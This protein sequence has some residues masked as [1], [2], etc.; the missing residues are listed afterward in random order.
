MPEPGRAPRGLG[1]SPVVWTLGVALGIGCAP[2][3]AAQ[4]GAGSEGRFVLG[5]RSVD[6]GGELDK[7][8][9]D[10][11]LG[12]GPRLM[13]LDLSFVPEGELRTLVD[14]VRVDVDDLGGEPFESLRIE[15]QRHGR[16]DFE[17]NRHESDYF[18]QDQLFPAD[19]VNVRSARAGDFHTFDFRRVRD[20]ASLGVDLAERATLTLGFD[21][22]RKTGR[23]TRA[24][25]LQR[26]EFE[27]DRPIDETSFE[28]HFGFQ[29]SWDRVTLSLEERYTRYENAYELFLPGR[30]AGQFPDDQTVLDY[31]FLDQPY[32]FTSRAHTVR[33]VSTPIGGLTVR[34]G[35][36]LQSLDLDLAAREEST[37]TGFDGAP[38]STEI[39]GEGALERGAGLWDL[40]VTYHLSEGWSVTGGYYHRSL[41]QEGDFLFG[42]VARRARWDMRTRG[43]EG[44]V[45]WAPLGGI[46]L[47]VGL[48]SESR[49]VSRA[50]DEAEQGPPEPLELQERDTGHRGYFGTLAWRPARGL[51]VS[52]DY[53]DSSIDD[54]FTLASATDRSRLRA[55]GRYNLENGL[56]LSA[57]YQ[58]SGQENLGS[59][60]DVDQ[61]LGTLRGGYRS[62]RINTHVG[63]SRVEIDRRYEAEVEGTFGPPALFDVDDR[64]ASRFVDGL[65][66]FR[67]TDDLW[68]G[69]QLRMHDNDGSFGVSRRDARLFGEYSFLDGY[70][71][72]LSLR[73]TDYD[74][75]EFDFD[76]YDAV[77]VDFGVGYSW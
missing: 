4:D 22:Y 12:D 33:L 2:A 70:L 45:Q 35:G 52:L 68:L 1:R 13:D 5:Y 43:I 64:L 24:L 42:D 3:A 15:A 58:R 27:L 65:V 36:T 31:F 32:E 76:D 57:S 40:D 20:R 73:Q 61:I 54:P 34:M 55:S 14:R 48:R 26:D 56:W 44:A 59:S 21:R 50:A 23:S 10:V 38:F 60:W 28:S 30:S 66:R 53:E 39:E 19:D 63:Y 17:Y 71:V 18:Y 7:Y 72:R 46:D 25:S 8:R 77:I 75:A 29:Y 11:N 9:E 62:E 37:G 47:T 69:G 51:S 49:D 41:D 74:E 16:Y 6:V 67:A